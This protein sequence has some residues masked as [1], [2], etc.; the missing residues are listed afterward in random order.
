VSSTLK[1]LT[2]VWSDSLRFADPEAQQRYVD[3]HLAAALVQSNL[4]LWSEASTHDNTR[5]LIVFAPYAR[6]ELELL[7]QIDGRLAELNEIPV[8]VIDVRL[9]QHKEH[10]NQIVPGIGRAPQTP[11]MML[12]RNGEAVQSGW[13]RDAIRKLR[14]LFDL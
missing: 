13:G 6:T 8:Q 9:I 7:D 4:A 11:I 12:W 1:P 14:E 3:Q 2:Q 10:F 5:L